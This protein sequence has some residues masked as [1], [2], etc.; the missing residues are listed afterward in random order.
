[1]FVMSSKLHLEDDEDIF[2]MERIECWSCNGEII[3]YYSEKYKGQRGKCY[4][5]ETDFPL[6]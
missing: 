6:E 4:S 1:M 5:C 3:M 2:P